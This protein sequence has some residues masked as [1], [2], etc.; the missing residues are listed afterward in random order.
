MDYFYTSKDTQLITA[1]ALY[2]RRCVSKFGKVVKV[3]L[4]N[5][6]TKQHLGDYENRILFLCQN[7][8][9]VLS[10]LVLIDDV[11]LIQTTGELSKELQQENGLTSILEDDP[12]VTEAGTLLSG[13]N[14]PTWERDNEAQNYY[15]VDRQ[16]KAYFLSES[17]YPLT[18]DGEVDLTSLNPTSTILCSLSSFIY[19]SGALTIIERPEFLT[20]P[21]QITLKAGQKWRTDDDTYSTVTIIALSSK[22]VFFQKSTETPQA[23]LEDK[24]R[25]TYNQQAT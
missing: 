4:V 6:F 14:F 17:P 25:L 7:Y 12:I 24:F 18:K 5:S 9:D 1:T 19:S 11:V 3:P 2:Q 20:I 22:W 16:G 21:E 15:Y 8:L 10:L 23:L 13:I